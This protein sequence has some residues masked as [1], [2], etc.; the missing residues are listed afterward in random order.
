MPTVRVTLFGNL[1]NVMA[2][3][4]KSDLLVKTMKSHNLYLFFSQCASGQNFANPA[5]SLALG[6]GRNFSILPTNVSL[7]D[8]LKFPFFLT[9]NALTCRSFSKQIFIETR[10]MEIEFK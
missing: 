10:G 3:L 8:D 1:V 7:C 4:S 2:P 6:A 5:I 9:L